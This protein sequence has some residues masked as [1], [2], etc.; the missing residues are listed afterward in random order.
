MKKPYKSKCY[1]TNLRRATNTITKYYN[2]CFSEISLSVP[3]YY[4][5]VNLSKLKKATAG[6]LSEYIGLERSTVVR[7]IQIMVKHGWVC[8]T[9][10]G[11]GSR[12]IFELSQ[13]GISTLEK[14]NFLWEEAQKNII[15]L[16][17]EEDCA[18][19]IRI[20]EKLWELR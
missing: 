5:L 19:L 12:N 10:I 8:E 6:E 7:N 11:R 4:L 16:L 18:A 3:Q 9:A 1:C 13:F 15:E 2:Q 20:S 17:G 14:A